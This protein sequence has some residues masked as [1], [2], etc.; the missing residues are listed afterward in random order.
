MT[1]STA[2]EAAANTVATLREVVSPEVRIFVG[3][4]A[5]HSLDEAIALGAN[6]WASDVR[7]LLEM[8]APAAA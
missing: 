2:L 8:L 6:G 4:A 7:S 1:S 3:G 5:V